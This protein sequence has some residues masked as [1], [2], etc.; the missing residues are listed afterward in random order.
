MSCD[1]STNAALFLTRCDHKAR[2][3]AECVPNARLL[4]GSCASILLLTTLLSTLLY[5]VKKKMVRFI[6]ST[7]LATNGKA[8][9]L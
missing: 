6:H 2:R 9:I 3:R 4:K 8:L 7:K 1:A 5:G